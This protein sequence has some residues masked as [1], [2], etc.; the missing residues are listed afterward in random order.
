V[1]CTTDATVAGDGWR[2][3]L[4][5]EGMALA[6]RLTETYEITNAGMWVAPT[7]GDDKRSAAQRFRLAATPVAYEH[8]D[9]HDEP[10]FPNGSLITAAP[11]N[12]AWCISDDYWGGDEGGTTLCFEAGKGITG[13]AAFFSG[14]FTDDLYVG[15]VKRN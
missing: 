14:G 15:D 3:E 8:R 12:G 5:C 1:T 7:G 13:A 11:R 2:V 4:A 9:E 6:D 10:D